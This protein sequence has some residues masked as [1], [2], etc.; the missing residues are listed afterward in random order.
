MILLSL[1]DRRI[2]G[3][4]CFNGRRRARLGVVCSG[5][6]EKRLVGGLDYMLAA[7]AEK[8]RDSGQVGLAGSMVSKWRR[9]F[10]VGR[11]RGLD[12]AYRSGK[13]SVYGEETE[14]M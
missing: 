5:K 9:R 3:G 1:G 11:M 7:G 14:R 12:D 10:A 8:H 4:R 2:Y 13:P 6:A